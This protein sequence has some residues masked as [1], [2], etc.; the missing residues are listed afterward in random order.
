VGSPV[1]P[2]ASVILPLLRQRRRNRVDIAVLSH[3]HPDH[4]LGLATALAAVSVGELWDTGQG[5]EQGAGPEY[6]AM[7]TDLEKRGIPVRGPGAL[8]GPA[9]SVG[10]VELSVFEPCPSFEPTLGPNDNSFIIKVEHGQ[11]SALFMGDAE[12]AAEQRLLEEHAGSLRADL[13]KAGHHGSR[14]STSPELLQAVRPRFATIS[15]GVRNRFGH[16]HPFTL[17]ALDATGIP[18]LRTDRLGSV[19]WVSDGE[20]DR[21][22]AFGGAF[23]ERWPG[24]VW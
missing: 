7:L 4:Y 14:T 6:H 11:R 1:N 19:E 13:L 5:R 17:A 22:R 8:C 21:T 23:A 20:A 12:R 3:P 9:R 2:G 15:C 18:A 16:P 10:G 24:F